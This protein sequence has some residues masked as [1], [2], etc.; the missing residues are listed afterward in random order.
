MI[1]NVPFAFTHDIYENSCSMSPTGGNQ[2]DGSPPVPSNYD[3]GVLDDRDI[4]R[5][6]IKIDR[7]L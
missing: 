2:V 7:V 5:Q 1:K 4:G 6:F 3:A